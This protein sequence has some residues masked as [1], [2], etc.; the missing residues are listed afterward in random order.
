MKNNNF[1]SYTILFSSPSTYFQ[2]IME[3]F[4]YLKYF[5]IAWIYMLCEYKNEY[6]G[7]FLEQKAF[8][9]RILH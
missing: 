5:Q 6:Q 1:D 3:D 9:D 2:I 8:E 4:V 7:L